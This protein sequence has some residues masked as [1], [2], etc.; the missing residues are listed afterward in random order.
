M[1]NFIKSVA[2]LF[3]SIGIAACNEEFTVN[4]PNQTN[5][6]ASKSKSIKIGEPVSFKTPINNATSI[7]WTVSPS[8]KSNIAPN[9][10]NASILFTSPGN[11]TVNATSGSSRLSSSV[12]VIDSFFTS[13]DTY[14]P[15]P[16]T[17]GEQLDITLARIDTVTTTNT[18]TALQFFVKT[19]KSY[20]CINAILRPDISLANGGVNI[21]FANVFTPKT[22]D[23]GTGKALTYFILFN[24]LNNLTIN[25]NNTKYSGSIV[26]EGNKYVVKWPYTSGVLISPTTL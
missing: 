23:A 1:Q 19:T 24:G 16:F 10:N 22:C 5:M 12:S 18:I 4:S 21:N 3:L 9:G 7:N 14:L 17:A 26:K 25:F 6:V 15:I 11:Y 20:T 8:S 2:F 13:S